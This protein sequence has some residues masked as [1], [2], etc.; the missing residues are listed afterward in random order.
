MII[1]GKVI[2]LNVVQTTYPTGKEPPMSPLEPKKPT[3]EEEKD[4]KPQQPL[5][6]RRK[7]RI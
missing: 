3:K 4:K 2:F 1:Y 6:I 5:G 7:T